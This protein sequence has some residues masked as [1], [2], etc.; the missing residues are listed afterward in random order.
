MAYIIFTSPKRWD[1]PSDKIS[2][3]CSSI[4]GNIGRQDIDCSKSDIVVCP[5]GMT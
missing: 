4:I 1:V 5:L 2:A 3:L